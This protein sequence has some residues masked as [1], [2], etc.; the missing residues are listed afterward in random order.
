MD[1][2]K[3]LEKVLNRLNSYQVNGEFT[4]NI[5]TLENIDRV[6]AVITEVLTEEGYFNNLK[7][8]KKE[9]TANLNESISNYKSFG[10]T[11]SPDLTAYNNLAFKNFY[12]RL[13]IITE[14]NIKQPIQDALLQHIASGG[15]YKTFKENL[16]EIVVGKKIETNIDL[17]AREVT[18]QYKR[19]QSMIL[20]DKFDIKYFKYSGDDILTSRCFCQQRS[21]NIY[22][23]EEIMKWADL[24]WGGQ[25]KGTNRNNIMQVLGGFN[26]RHDLLPISERRAKN[27][28]INNY[29]DVDCE[30]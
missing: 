13:L 22:T 30:L 24:E 1:Y 4:F 2:E 8:Y 6:D 27:G 5:K 28:L 18:F 9:F 21:G 3:I 26:C 14:T 29:N 25:I 17:L 15:K 23:R 7:Q 19:S 10:A 20:A 12:N 16:R 11:V